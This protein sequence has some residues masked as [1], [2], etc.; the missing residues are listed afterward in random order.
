LGGFNSVFGLTGGFD[1]Q[2]LV[3]QLM[4]VER[5]PIRRLDTRINQ[6]QARIDAYNQLNSHLSELLSSLESLNDENAFGAKSTTS[7]NE[8][9]LTATASGS[10][11]EG[12]YLIRVDRLALFDN[13]ASDMR[14]SATGE[15]IGTGGFDLVVGS[16]V[17]AIEIDPEDNTL[18]G[19]RRAINSSGADVNAGIIHDGV[20]YRMTLTSRN[21]G[22][23]HTISIENN[24][25]TLSDGTTPLLFSRTHDID[26]TGQLDAAITVNGLAVTSS[27]N[28]VENVI[29]GLTLNLRDVSSSTVTLTVANDTAQVR[30]NIEAFVESYNKAYRFINSQFQFVD[31]TGRSGVLA[32]ELTVREIQLQ[33]SQIVTGSVPGLSGAL[34]T[35]GSAG[36]D[37][38]NDGTLQINTA[39][40]DERLAGNFDDLKDLALGYTSQLH[41]L[42][43]TITDSLEG[44][45]H[46]AVEGYQ[47]DIKS[48]R[49]RIE[50]T[51]DRLAARE[52]Y[53]IT[54]FSRAN[55]A[56][57]QLQYLQST[58]SAQ[59]NQLNFPR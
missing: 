33:L 43:S 42:V 27:S 4:Y 58:L 50:Y 52:D 47:S 45:I 2:S 16:I 11:S 37:M 15:T 3:A 40:L 35:L 29:E 31:A 38:R 32:T 17:T 59:L 41:R 54:Q 57:Q 44:P 9:I 5:A 14:F 22:A 25:L 36:I 8:G 28:T 34:K 1:V 21:S 13:H 49:E 6:F 46:R 24:T 30:K 48:I 19:L 10:A 51:E 55:Q 56:L 20:G 12:A 7:S 26:D 53:L 23:A 18:E 39:V